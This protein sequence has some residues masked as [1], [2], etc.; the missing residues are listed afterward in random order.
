MKKN[1]TTVYLCFAL[2]TCIILS[3]G[4]EQQ[5]PD[6]K[7]NYLKYTKYNTSTYR[8]RKNEVPDS[9]FQMVNLTE[10]G[11]PGMECDTSGPWRRITM[12]GYKKD[13]CYA[14][15]HMPAGLSN[16]NKLE[17]LGL[18]GNNIQEI[19]AFI[20]NLKKLKIL[21][22]GGNPITVLPREIEELKNLEILN[23]QD[24]ALEAVP[25]INK[26]PKLEKVFLHGCPITKLPDD[27]SNWKNLKLLGL[28]RTK[29]DKAEQERIRRALPN[30]RIQFPSD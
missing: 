6:K 19:P 18:S 11:I 12:E 28:H 17:I 7:N 13:T 1:P 14:L 25:F 27:L 30:C 24:C 5:I 29:L 2:I 4:N 22:L 10:L 15:T 20:K 3:C 8:L 26:L 23:L 16:L 21:A 9:V